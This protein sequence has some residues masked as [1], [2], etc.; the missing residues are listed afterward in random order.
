MLRII[1]KKRIRIE[2]FVFAPK[3]SG[4]SVSYFFNN[5]TL[6]YTLATPLYEHFVH[7]HWHYQWLYSTMNSF[8]AM[9]AYISV[10]SRPSSLQSLPHH[11]VLLSA[12]FL[13]KDSQ[14]GHYDDKEEKPGGGRRLHS[15][16]GRRG[17][18]WM[19]DCSLASFLHYV[20]KVPAREWTSLP[21]SINETQKLLHTQRPIS[22][23]ILDTVTEG[24]GYTDDKG[25][26]RRR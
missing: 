1:L 17:E 18:R 24:R 25:W 6:W 14:P 26:E 3:H 10:T 22:R 21:N 20:V 15:G 8:M 9:I 4:A 2:D 11:G 16:K 12:D 23:G 7:F 19:H 13:R 5:I